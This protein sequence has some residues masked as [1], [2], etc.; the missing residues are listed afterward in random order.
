MGKFAPRGQYY[1]SIY[2]LNKTRQKV[3]RECCDRF[4]AGKE[5]Y[6]VDFLYGSK[7]ERYSVSVQMPMLAT[8]NLMIKNENMFNMME[9]KIERITEDGNMYTIGGH[10]FEYSKFSQCF[11][12]AFC[13]AVCK[14]HGAVIDERY[15]FYNVNRMDKKKWNTALSRTKKVRMYPS[16]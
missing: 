8:Q 13:C 16:Q 3:T 5:S 14:Y 12:P 1:K 9:F 4:V 15:N 11:I 7:R 6:E 2:H 10:T